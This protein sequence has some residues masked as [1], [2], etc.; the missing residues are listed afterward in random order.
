MPV[1]LANPLFFVAR[2]PSTGAPLDLSVPLPY[3]PAF[4]NGHLFFQGFVVG[5]GFAQLT[6]SVVVRVRL[7]W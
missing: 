1:L 5:T 7:A 3:T 2:G 6:N 4:A